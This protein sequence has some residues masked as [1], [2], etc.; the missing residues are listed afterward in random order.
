MELKQFTVQ[1]V[2]GAKN[3]PEIKKSSTLGQITK[4]AMCYSEQD[5]GKTLNWLKNKLCKLH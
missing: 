1:H 3:Q 2:N 5:S 4:K